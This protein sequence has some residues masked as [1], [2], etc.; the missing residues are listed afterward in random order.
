MAAHELHGL[1][2]T[3]PGRLQRPGARDL[4]RGPRPRGGRLRTDR[5]TLGELR[6]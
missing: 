3:R 6:P 2:G 5:N 4:S 1:A